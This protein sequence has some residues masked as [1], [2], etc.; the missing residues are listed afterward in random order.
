MTE[1]AAASVGDVSDKQSG[2]IRSP[3]VS[4]QDVIS[5][6]RFFLGRSPENDAVIDLYCSRNWSLDDLRR[7]FMS[8]AEFK[9]KQPALVSN[10][11]QKPLD[12]PKSDVEVDVSEDQMLRMIREIGG[13]GTPLVRAHIRSIQA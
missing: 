5:A 13:G 10:S 9:E 11:S 4:R 12:W 6:F 3:T 1:V 8:S 7:A 2:A